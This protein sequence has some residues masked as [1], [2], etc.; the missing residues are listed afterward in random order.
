MAGRPAG[1]STM[2]ER[3]HDPAT[4]ARGRP[5]PIDEAFSLLASTVYDP[6]IALLAKINIKP[7]VMTRQQDPYAHQGAEI[8]L[9]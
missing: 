7:Q 4:L 8:P 2:S 5:E 6:L 9:A 3:R 1:G